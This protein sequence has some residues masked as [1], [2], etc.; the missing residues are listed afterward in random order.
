CCQPCLEGCIQ[1]RLVGIVTGFHCSGNRS[2][3]YYW[4]CRCY[5]KGGCRCRRLAEISGCKG[6]CYSTTC[7]KRSCTCCIISKYRCTT[8]AHALCCQP[9]LEGCIQSRLV[10]IV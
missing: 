2:C 7:T 5:R 8:A 10:G 1:S 4:R 3:Y 6:H 9:C